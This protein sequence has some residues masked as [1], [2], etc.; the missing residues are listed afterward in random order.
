MLLAIVISLFLYP[1]IYVDNT[2]TLA[3]VSTIN[4][5][6][7]L[8][9]L[10]LRSESVSFIGI[11]GI[12]VLPKMELWILLIIQRWKWLGTNDAIYH[13]TVGKRGSV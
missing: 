11:S 7:N 6:K 8:Q 3:L 1:E 2:I 4:S 9:L 13:Q 5:S 10:T 12:C